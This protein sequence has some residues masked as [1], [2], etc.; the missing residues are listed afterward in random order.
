MMNKQ[1]ILNKSEIKTKITRIQF[2]IIEDYYMEQSVTLIGF[3][4]NGHT[5]GK[6]IKK[7]IEKNHN[8][9][10]TLHSIKNLDEY[11]YRYKKNMIKFDFSKN[12]YIPNF[13]CFGQLEFDHYKRYGIKVKNFYKAGSLRLANF[14]HTI[15]ES[16]IEVQKPI[17]DICLIIDK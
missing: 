16:K 1:I 15:K 12:Y 5:I 14:F 13:F 6:K 10:V 17:Y 2:S 9:N 3:D 4:K 11:Q 8:I 7:I